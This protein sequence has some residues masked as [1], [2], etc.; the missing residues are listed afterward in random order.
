[1]ASGLWWCTH[2]D[3]SSH[4]QVRVAAPDRVDEILT[5][6]DGLNKLHDFSPVDP[7]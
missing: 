6:I 5:Q 4:R 7:T 3:E 1:M 2:E